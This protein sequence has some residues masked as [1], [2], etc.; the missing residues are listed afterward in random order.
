[1][2]IGGR[3]RYRVQQG[4][5]L[6]GEISI[7]APLQ[8]MPVVIR[9]KWVCGP[10]AKPCRSARVIGYDWLGMFECVWGLAHVHPRCPTPIGVRGVGFVC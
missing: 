9:L 8:P 2:G 1:M 5:R 3:C 7:Q 6:F 4:R 10:S